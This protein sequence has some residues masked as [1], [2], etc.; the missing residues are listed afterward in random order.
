LPGVAYLTPRRNLG[1]A[2][3]W[4]WL[5]V[6]AGDAHVIISNDDTAFAPDTIARLMDAAERTPD[7]GT[8]SA[9]DGQK[10]SLFYLRRMC[11]DA[12]GPF[13]EAFYPAY[14]EDNDYVQRMTLGGW[15]AIAAPSDV[16]H[17]ASSTRAA[18]SEEA[19][20]RSHQAFRRCAAYF[21]AKWGNL[22]HDGPLFDAPFGVRA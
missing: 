17:Q 7:A 4:N 1:V 12:V 21:V 18:M 13:D 6:E 11:Y 19:Q 14:F 16:Q 2:A 22:P 8:V 15:R 20:A 9:I 10:F 3:A 5:M